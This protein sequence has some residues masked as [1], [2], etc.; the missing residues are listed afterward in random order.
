MNTGIHRE[1]M[2]WRQRGR[3]RPCAWNH[4]STSLGTPRIASKHQKLEEARKDYPLELSETVWP[5]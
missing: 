1:K 2:M 3:R 5:C 4:A